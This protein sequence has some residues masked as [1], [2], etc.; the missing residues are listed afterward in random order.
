M[1]QEI[2]GHK[3]L[4]MTARYAH[5]GTAH[6]L[7]AVALLEQAYQRPQSPP[8]QLQTERD[9]E[10]YSVASDAADATEWQQNRQQA[11]ET[12]FSAPP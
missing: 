6:K 2:L 1:V 12:T 11:P 10:G 9:Q 4:R 5:V 3:D 8:G 7:A